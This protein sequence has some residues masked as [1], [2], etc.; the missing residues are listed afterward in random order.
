MMIPCFQ[1]SNHHSEALRVFESMKESH[2][3]T[4]VDYHFWLRSLLLF[5]AIMLMIR[6]SVAHTDELTTQDAYYVEELEWEKRETAKVVRKFCTMKKIIPDVLKRPP[7]TDLVIC[8]GE[9]DN[10]EI[11]FGN[12][13]TPSNVSHPPTE[14]YWRTEPNYL[15][16]LVLVDPDAPDMKNPT[17]REY[18]HWIVGNIPGHDYNKGQV[19]VPYLGACDPGGEGLHRYIFILY[20]HTEKVA[21]KEPKLDDKPS[22]K[23]ANFSCNS[24][25]ARYNLGDP[26]GLNFFVV[27]WNRGDYEDDVV[28]LKY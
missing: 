7:V 20:K 19:I 17:N 25:A 26:Y 16:T 13:F 4:L 3:V 21:F 24:F 8:Y 1:A 11:H 9:K 18:L 22:N 12:I 10:Q 14:T 23:R 2:G 5:M 15:Y 28:K 27:G 6:Y